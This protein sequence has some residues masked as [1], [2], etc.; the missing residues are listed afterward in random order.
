MHHEI[1]LS[2]LKKA[3][4]TFDAPT[5]LRDLSNDYLLLCPKRKAYWAR[6]DGAAEL[7][8]NPNICFNHASI[9][10][11]SADQA[12]SRANGKRKSGVNIVLLTKQQ[13]KLLIADMNSIIITS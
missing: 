3:S 8:C 11:N 4:S 13:K 10:N 6:T 2:T 1:V 5:L 12:L 9:H 7:F